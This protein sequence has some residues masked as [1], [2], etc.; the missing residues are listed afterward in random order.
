ME[1]TVTPRDGLYGPSSVTWRVHTEPILWVAGVRALY[2]QALHPRTMR[3]TAQNSLLMDPE[4]AWSRFQRTVAFVGVR[5]FGTRAQVER[6]ARRVR[7]I[8]ARLRGLDPDTGEIY[9]LDDPE[10]LLWVHCGEIDSYLDVARRAGVPLTDAEAD[11]YVDEQRRSAEVV[12]LDPALA[13]GSVAELAAFFDGMRPRLHACAEAREG[14]RRSFNP[15][16]PRVLLPLKLGPLPALGA[17][18]FATLPP[19]ARAMYG[20]PGSAATDVGATAALR[21]LRRATL[22]IPARLASPE[23]REARRLMREAAAPSLPLAS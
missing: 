9:R 18:A 2:L 5:T 17:L 14:L 10:N 12:G 8:H 1:L 23:I 3:G 19:W 15:P 4:H 22:R 16:L 6:A 20:T 11:A 7:M 21:A 13:P